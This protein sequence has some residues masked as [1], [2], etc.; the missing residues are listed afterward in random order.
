L[1]VAKEHPTGNPVPLLVLGADPDDREAL[2]S[3]RHPF[4]PG[5]PAARGVRNSVWAVLAR[6]RSTQEKASARVFACR[7][8]CSSG[9]WSMAH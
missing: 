1:L 4:S 9:R 2:L 7:A 5:E 6:R 8:V 3:V